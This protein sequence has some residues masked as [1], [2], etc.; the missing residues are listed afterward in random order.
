MM[1]KVILSIVTALSLAV[2]ACDQTVKSERHLAYPLTKSDNLPVEKQ[3]AVTKRTLPDW[4]GDHF[5]LKDLGEDELGTPHTLVS[6]VVAGKIK[7][8]DTVMACSVLKKQEFAQHD[9]PETAIDACGGWW[10]GAGDYF[11]L[12]EKNNQLQVFSGWLDEGQEDETYHWK[13]LKVF[14]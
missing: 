10:A 3:E 12:I 7:V 13:K 2:A 5:L 8:I 14:K 11:Y 4:Q 6:V 1:Q 9:I